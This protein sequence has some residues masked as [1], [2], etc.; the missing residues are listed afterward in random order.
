M[1]MTFTI[2]ALLCLLL[3]T[4]F[5]ALAQ[6]DKPTIA[7]LRYAATG[8]VLAAADAILDSLEA[9]GYLT[10]A[11]R[12]SVTDSVDLE[13]ENIN[14]MYRDAGFDLPAVSLMVEEALDAGADALI[15]VTTLVAQTAVNATRGMDDPP[16][17]I[18]SLVTTPF[19]TGI[20][21]APCIKPDHVTGSQPLIPYEEYVPLVLLQNPD[22]KT[23]GTIVTPDQPTSVVGAE[24]IGEIAESLGLT[25]EVAT[26][27]NIADLSLAA[28]SLAGKG[29]EAI[30]LVINPLSLQ[31]TPAMV[32]VTI[33]HGIP[34]YA[35]V[36]QQAHRGVTVA[37]GF[38]SFYGEGVIVGRILN[39]HLSGE[40]DIAELGINQS[41][42]FGVALN[43]DTAAAQ[44]ITISDDL[45][46]LATFVVEDGEA[47]AGMAA[48]MAVSGMTLQEMT[49]E[50]RLAADMEFLAGLRCTEEMISEQRRQL[51]TQWSDD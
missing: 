35:P 36:I 43:L 12:D 26:A 51:E 22:I 24:I 33:D 29:V 37:A 49:L 13:G 32:Q 7:F 5:T 42:S 44:E 39:A 4:P 10:A 50:E 2:A 38:H 28:D 23:I 21:D 20:A 1:R 48:D 27:V 6:D 8:P 14:L 41:R 11:E 31:G 18:F 34:L 3:I 16:V 45:L 40:V 46:E 15:T 30:V 9:Y 19:A 47:S 25:L 17:I